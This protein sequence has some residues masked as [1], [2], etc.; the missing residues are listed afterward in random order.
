VVAALPKSASSVI[1]SC[2]SVIQTGA[3]DN[4]KY[5]SYM[6][7]NQDSDLRPEILRDFPEGG[8]VKYH[9]HPMSK[10][11]KILDTLGVRY[12]I[13]LRDPADQLVAS[14]VH[15]LNDDSEQVRGSRHQ[16]D[17]IFPLPKALFNADTAMEK[18][19]E[20]MIRGGYLIHSLSWMTD[21]LAL[22]DPQ[23]SA[24]V[25]YEDF[26]QDRMGVLNGISR[27]LTG[28]DFDVHLSER[29]GQIAESYKTK[30]AGAIQD[31]SRRYPRGWTGKIGTWRDYF[32]AENRKHYCTTVADFIRC[33]PSASALLQVYPDLL[34][35]GN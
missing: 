20:F 16:Y 15:N 1:G 28:H 32:S 3:K 12:L 27:W 18:A 30:Q 31:G 25:R 2:V 4:R 29:C 8:V 7:N 24:V 5:G 33:Y 19:F 34:T 6:L 13:I 10:N 21:W 14:Y 23:R 26:V 17:H 35:S 22:R 9:T 11:V